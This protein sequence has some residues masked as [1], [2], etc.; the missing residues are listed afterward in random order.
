MLQFDPDRVQQ[1]L[2]SEIPL[3][4]IHSRMIQRMATRLVAMLALCQLFVLLAIL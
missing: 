2:T 1:H 4:R 3:G